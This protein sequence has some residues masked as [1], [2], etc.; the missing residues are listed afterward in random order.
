LPGVLQ[1]GVQRGLLLPGGPQPELV[2]A[3]HHM[4]SLRRP[5]RITRT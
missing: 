5:I 3:P 2:R 4:A 1:A